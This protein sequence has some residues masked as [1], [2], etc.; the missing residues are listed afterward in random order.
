MCNASRYACLA[1]IATGSG[2]N[3]ECIQDSP[4]LKNCKGIVANPDRKN[5]FHQTIFRTEQDV[6]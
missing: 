2:T 1:M 4:G 5:V 6:N 3:I